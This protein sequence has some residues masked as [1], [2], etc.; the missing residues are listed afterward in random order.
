MF[1]NNEFMKLY[2]E[3]SELNEGGNQNTAQIYYM[4]EIG[5]FDNGNLIPASNQSA[6]LLN[7]LNVEK[8][9]EINKPQVQLDEDPLNWPKLKVDDRKVQYIFKCSGCTGI[10]LSKKS[11]DIY[12]YR[13]RSRDNQ[14]SYSAADMV[15]CRSC[16]A[17]KN[18]VAKN[19]VN[20]ESSIVEIAKP[21]WDRLPDKLFIDKA[22]G[23]DAVLSSF[24]Y[25]ELLR[26][27]RNN[28]DKI[29]DTF[30]QALQQRS[31]DY[32]V[33]LNFTKT[34]GVIL[35]FHCPD[36]GQDYETQLYNAVRDD[37]YGCINCV[38]KSRGSQS[39]RSER[40]LRAA[41]LA[42]FGEEAEIKNPPKLQGTKY[43]NVDILFNFKGQPIAIE[44]DGHGFHKGKQIESDINKTKLYSDN[45]N[46][47]FIR[48]REAGAEPFPETLATVITISKPFLRLE[49]ADYLKCLEAICNSLGH[50]LSKEAKQNLC[51]VFL[52]RYSY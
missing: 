3:L 38:N 35:P 40:F 18:G 13:S 29:P 14:C 9:I 8:T 24:G 30:W 48:I 22:K 15:L 19:K 17:K 25:T 39:S 46:Y 47:K 45:Y 4:H 7:Y 34:A 31:N 52:N 28:A 16:A 1:L 36:C 21:V 20:A 37:Y 51:Q 32:K 33:V 23:K 44:Y 26:L 2:E 43:R 42:I 11:R 6:S 49:E 10:E 41:L 50:K 5:G 12:G 27:N